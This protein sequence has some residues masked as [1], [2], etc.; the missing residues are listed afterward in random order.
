MR[1][2]ELRKLVEQITAAESE[3]SWRTVNSF[4]VSNIGALKA[5]GSFVLSTN[6]ILA[7]S[8][9]GNATAVQLIDAEADE[10][11]LVAAAFSDDV[12]AGVEIDL[13]LRQAEIAPGAQALP[14]IAAGP[15][16]I[17]ELNLAGLGNNDV[18][19]GSGEPGAALF[20]SLCVTEIEVRAPGGV[21]PTNGNVIL[22]GQLQAR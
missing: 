18:A 22:I 10:S 1:L 16:V 17:C 21:W 11:R 19:F 13:R 15:E 14:S 9:V 7:L 2:R 12:T 5:P 8:L 3:G 4:L 6:S 20:P